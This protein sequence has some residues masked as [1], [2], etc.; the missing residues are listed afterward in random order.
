MGLMNLFWF[1]TPTG[2]FKRRLRNTRRTWDRLREKVDR[3]DYSTKAELLDKLDTI[4][5][6]IRTLERK[7]EDMNIRDKR[8]I[9]SQVENSLD[10]VKDMIREEEIS[11]KKEVREI[12]GKVKN[13]A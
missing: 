8:K 13:Y 1:L 9:V 7:E 3:K 5:Q 4:E 2:Q 11:Q 6:D 12:E 10:E